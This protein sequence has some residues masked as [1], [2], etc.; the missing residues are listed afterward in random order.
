MS[1]LLLL[2][3]LVLF[4]VA[5]ARLVAEGEWYLVATLISGLLMARED[6]RKLFHEDEHRGQ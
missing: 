6:I 5:L 1:K 3:L 2:M 4:A